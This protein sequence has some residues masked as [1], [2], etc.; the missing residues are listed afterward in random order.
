MRPPG[1][2]L[3]PGLGRHTKDQR[4]ARGGG[5]PTKHNRPGWTN[6]RIPKKGKKCRTKGAGKPRQPES[7]IDVRPAS[8]SVTSRFNN[9]KKSSEWS[10]KRLTWGQYSFLCSSVVMTSVHLLTNPQFLLVNPG[11]TAWYLLMGVNVLAGL[12]LVLSSIIQVRYN[13]S[14]VVLRRLFKLTDVKIYVLIFWLGRF[15]VC[16]VFKGQS[17]FAVA[18]VYQFLVFYTADSW[19]LCDRVCIVSLAVHL[20]LV[21]V[22]E[23]TMNNSPYK[24]QG[25]VWVWLN[26][27]TSANNLSAAN[28]LNLGFYLIDCLVRL[29][30]DPNRR[31]FV[32][33]TTKAT[34]E[35]FT[36]TEPLLR[37]EKLAVRFIYAIFVFTI[38]LWEHTLIFGSRLDD[39]VY[40]MISLALI[41]A[42]VSATHYW[43]RYPLHSHAAFRALLRERKIIYVTLLFIALLCVDIGYKASAHWANPVIITIAFFMYALIDRTKHFHVVFAR[44]MAIG[45]SVIS[46]YVVA[47]QTFLSTTCGKIRI[48]FGAFGETVT[49][50]EVKR[51]IF[52]SIMS[53]F[54]SA[55]FT[56]RH[57]N[58][59]LFVNL[60]VSRAT[61]GAVGNWRIAGEVT[62]RTY[63]LSLKTELGGPGASI[64]DQTATVSGAETNRSKSTEVIIAQN[65]CG[66]K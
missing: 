19:Y 32:S 58:R 7:S 23:W 60:R 46:L 63:E 15:V 21:I 66:K 31:C 47:D 37:R 18:F 65:S 57:K 22:Y 11:T 13:A 34:R 12:V 38:V 62:N 29:Y 6:E 5:A 48:P 50:C 42:L 10:K 39:T 54:I 49:V 55:F 3:Q 25:P 61:G 14:I 20:L 36:M 45:L 64:A 17:V 16:E 43:Q 56:S 44:T 24:M 53:L 1:K 33:L 27:R 4:S 51:T 8:T 26:I 35:T 30:E 40:S 41:I 9:Y 2:P 59:L 52:T 28:Y